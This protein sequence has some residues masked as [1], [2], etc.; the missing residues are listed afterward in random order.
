MNLEHDLLVK[1]R[2]ARAELDAAN[3]A[4]ATAQK[5]VDRLQSEL[6]ELLTEKGATSTAKYDGIGFATIPKEPKLY[7]NFDKENQEDVFDFLKKR[8]MGDLIKQ[9][10]NRSSL[11]SYVKQL[12]IDGEEL[13]EF[14]SYYIKPTVTLYQR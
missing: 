10:V 6:F 7:A 9:D 11:S 5:N 3:K 2:D 4:K 8:G 12:V 13:P 14:I 1:L